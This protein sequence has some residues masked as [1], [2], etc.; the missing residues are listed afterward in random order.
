MKKVWL[1]EEGVKTLNELKDMVNLPKTKI[2]AL[3]LKILK[4][5]LEDPHLCYSIL[6]YLSYTDI[7]LSNELY[8]ARNKLKQAESLR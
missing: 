4:K 5:I 7:P 8:K 6:T 3:A 1:N 2:I